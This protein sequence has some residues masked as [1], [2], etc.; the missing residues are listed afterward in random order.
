MQNKIAYATA[1][2]IPYLLGILG[3]VSMFTAFDNAISTVYFWSYLLLG[4]LLMFG[5]WALYTAVNDFE[6]L[7]KS[8]DY[9][10]QDM[11]YKNINDYWAR[12]T[13]EAKQMEEEEEKDSLF[14]TLSIEDLLDMKHKY[15]DNQ[16]I[17]SIVNEILE[18][19]KDVEKEI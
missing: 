12:K 10:L 14:N 19:R 18:K 9:V 6:Q 7:T 2:L 8:Y 11:G 3:V 1:T 16:S 4:V 5:T 13:E 15:P 17:I